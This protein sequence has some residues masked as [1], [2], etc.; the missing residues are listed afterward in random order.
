MYKLEV[1][2]N[3]AYSNFDNIV[4]MHRKKVEEKGKIFVGDIITVKTKEEADYL[5]GDNPKNI[6]ACKIISSP[7]IENELDIKETY[8]EPTVS[9]RKRRKKRKLNSL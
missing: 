2:E 1:I 7:I 4:K 6:V 9:E 8:L 3:V 5:C